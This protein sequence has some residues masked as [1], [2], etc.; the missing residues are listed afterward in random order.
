MSID[1]WVVDERGLIGAGYYCIDAERL[2]ER[3]GNFYEWP[4][5]VHGKTWVNFPAFCVAFEHAL[6]VHGKRYS[7]QRL[8]ATVH[9]CI[10]RKFDSE[11]YSVVSR[12]L[13]PERYEGAI[14]HFFIHEIDQV[15]E[16]VQ[17][18]TEERLAHYASIKQTIAA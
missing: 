16:E 10:K 8:A 15:Y 6:Q 14:T 7:K 13:F 17:R 11:T 9:H 3:R 12:E 1:Q 18:R 2:L 4:L 5:Q